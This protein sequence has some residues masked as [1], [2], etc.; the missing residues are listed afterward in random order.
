MDPRKDGSISRRRFVKTT[1]AASVAA[2]G[3]PYVAGGALKQRP[4]RVGIVGCGGRGTGAMLNCVAADDQVRITAL[5]DVF[6]DR[7][8]SCR[9]RLKGRAGQS[10]ENK[11]CFIGFDAFAKLLETDV[12]IVILATPPYFRAEHLAAGID[13]GK[14]V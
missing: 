6:K 5:A 13:A 10:V 1:A 14:N 4:I 12:D 8:E 11:N 3:F 2:G 7:L 9:N